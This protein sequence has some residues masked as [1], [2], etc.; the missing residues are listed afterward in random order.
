MLAVVAC[1]SAPRTSSKFARPNKDSIVS[2][3]LS[4]GLAWFRWTRERP[5]DDFHVAPGGR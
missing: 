3:A 4:L 2:V 1:S 5:S